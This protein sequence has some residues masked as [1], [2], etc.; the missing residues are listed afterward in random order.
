MDRTPRDPN[1]NLYGT[2]DLGGAYGLG[3]VYV[4]KK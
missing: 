4:V 2:T 1:G 3:T